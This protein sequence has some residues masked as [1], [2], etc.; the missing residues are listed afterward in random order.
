[1]W[2]EQDI[3]RVEDNKFN[4]YFIF[5]FYFILILIF[6]L[7]LEFSVMLHI[8]IMN[9]HTKSQLHIVIEYCRRF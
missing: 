6:D 2:L 8:T 3:I 1:M 7:G 4:F 5:P 9:C